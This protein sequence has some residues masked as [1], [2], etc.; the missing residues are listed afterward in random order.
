MNRLLSICLTVSLAMLC[1]CQSHPSAALHPSTPAPEPEQ[2]IFELSYLTCAEV[3]A[4][5]AYLGLETQSTMQAPHVLAVTGTGP[6]LYRTKVLLSVVDCN[7]PYTVECLGPVSIARD[8]PTNGQIMTLMKDVTIG[9]FANPPTDMETRKILIDIL[10][11]KVMAVVPKAL[12]PQLLNAIHAKSSDRPADSGATMVQG[13]G[14][15]KPHGETMTPASESPMS[16]SEPVTSELIALDTQTPSRREATALVMQPVTPEYDANA[17]ESE[18]SVP[19]TDL[20]LTRSV[21]TDLNISDA[22]EVLDLALPDS[23]RLTELLELAGQYLGFDMVYESQKIPDDSITLKLHGQLQGKVRVQDLYALLQTVLKFKNLAMVRK[24][25]HLIA[26][27]PVAEVLDTDPA[28]I[29]PE[30]GKVQAGDLVV[31]RLFA[32]QH[33]GATSAKALLESMKL[34]LAISVI[35]QTQT[36]FVTCYTHRLDR[37]EQLI[38]LIDRPGEARFFRIRVLR[39]TSVESLTQQIQALAGQLQDMPVVVSGMTA[40]NSNT[41]PVSSPP[42]RDTPDLTG[43]KEA[44]YLDADVRTNRMIT[45]GSKPQ[46]DLIEKLITALDVPLHDQRQ[47]LPYRLMNIQ[48][49]QAVNILSQLLEIN[50]PDSGRITGSASTPG[51]GGSRQGTPSN[52]SPSSVDTP[53]IV[54]LDSVNTLLINATVQQHQRIDMILMYADAAPDEQRVL[55]TYPLRHLEATEVMTTLTE[56]DLLNAAVPGEGPEPA[57]TRSGV[58]SARTAP[59]NTS[60][61]THKGPRIS[62]LEAVNALLVYATEFQHK[63]LTALLQHIDVPTQDVAIP[64][65]IYFLENQPPAHMAEVLKQILEETV[66]DTQAKIEESLPKPQ[67]KIVI[68][69]DEPTCSLIVYA[70]KKNQDWIQ[71]LITTLDRRRPQVLIDVTLVEIRKTDEFTY[72]LNLITG[73]P[74]LA[75]TSGQIGSFTTGGQTVV[76][77][78]QSVNRSSFAEFQTNSGAGSGFYA[79]SHIN[80]LL[81]AMQSKNYGRILAKPKILVNDNETG[82]I[83]TTEMTYV[84]KKSSIPVSSGGA[85]ANTTLIETAVEYESYDAGITLEITPHTSEGDLLRLDIMLNRSDFGTITGETPPDESSSDLTTNVTVPDASTI[86]L[87]GMLRLNQTKAGKKVPILGDLPLIGLLF[88]GASNKDIQNKLYIFVR[89]EVIRPEETLQ[90]AQGALNRMSDQNRDAF[91]QHEKDFQ[92]YETLPGT[93]HERLDPENVLDMK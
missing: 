13:A 59:G 61:T 89:A 73:I 7:T 67:D 62:I 53:Q 72:D 16:G 70:S 30:G 56:L 50:Q 88:R 84:S 68:V 78:L 10:R 15:S 51:G 36:L 35:E 65:E 55:K 42:K 44:V 25:E 71:K 34:S 29:D 48:A 23:M 86:I 52:A 31:T 14:P 17:L 92:D 2:R 58:T 19:R 69:P 76:E 74:D 90:A 20:V 82:T 8:L 45:I 18:W 38:Q 83:K 26:V 47:M 21:L 24:D 32:L 64:Y 37:V 66:L 87:G 9:T 63:R 75:Q 22:N 3:Q 12:Y 27:V 49:N 11:E 6:D 33:V 41:G 1:G 39:Y 93:R 80:V 91:E 85:G 40:S 60:G 46:L 57:P 28:L 81:S 43:D 77:K 79:D 4:L 5:M 54:L